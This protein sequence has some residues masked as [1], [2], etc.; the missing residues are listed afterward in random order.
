MLHFIIVLCTDLETGSPLSEVSILKTLTAM[1]Q[2]GKFLAV[3]TGLLI[4]YV[5]L[6]AMH[7]VSWD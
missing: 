7:G 5:M 6:P 3:V 2:K 1:I 4:A